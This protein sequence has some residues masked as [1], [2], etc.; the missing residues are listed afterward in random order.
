[1]SLVLVLSIA[2]ALETAASP[3][4]AIAQ[5]RIAGGTAL[6]GYSM[7]P[8]IAPCGCVG[9]RR[10]SLAPTV[11]AA[12]NINKASGKGVAMRRACVSAGEGLLSATGAA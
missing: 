4:L 3:A 2:S 7:R 8:P 6:P 9:S 12:N 10:V 11:P 1:M 5:I